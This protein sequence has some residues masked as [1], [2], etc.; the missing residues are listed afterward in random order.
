MGEIEFVTRVF[1]GWRCDKRGC[2]AEWR[3]QEPFE[4]NWISR[5]EA[6]ANMAAD[7]WSIWV[8]RSR[9]VYCPKHGPSRGSKMWRIT[10]R[11]PK[12]TQA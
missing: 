6:E 5:R 11:D 7:G 9:H 3:L 2:G 12:E 10:P 1:Y 4:D 8:S